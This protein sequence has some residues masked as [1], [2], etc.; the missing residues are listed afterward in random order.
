MKKSRSARSSGSLTAQDWIEAAYSAMAEEGIGS[1]AV[2]PLARRLGI[3]R[4]SFYWHFENRRALLEA[5]LERW[6][7]ESTEA[8]IS[9]TRRVADPLERFV[10][11][12]EEALGEAP[13]DDDASGGDIFR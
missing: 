5:I 1:V 2:E 4:G 10:R 11:L 7:R 9:A 6:E 3:T 13:R 12:A 8:V